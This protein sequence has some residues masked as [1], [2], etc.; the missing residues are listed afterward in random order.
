M[1]EIDV[2]VPTEI[3][4]AQ[5]EHAIEAACRAHGLRVTLKGT[6]AQYPGSVHWHLKQGRQSGTLELTLWPQARRLWF[7]VGAHRHG[8]WMELVIPQL[9]QQLER[10]LS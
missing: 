7:K 4:W 1:L 2:K 5:W 6:L 10:I 8:A 9:K 3:E